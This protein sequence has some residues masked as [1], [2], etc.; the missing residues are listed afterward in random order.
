VNQLC[1]I[2]GVSRA[3]YYRFRRRHEPRQASMTLRNHIQQ[4]ALRWPAYGY[5]RVHAELVRQGWR[6]NHKRV[7]RLMRSDNLLCVR[8][9]K[10]LF[11]TDSRHSLPIYPN[12]VEELIVTSIDQLWV[13][14][15]TYIRL[16]L[17]FVYLAVLLDACSRR[18]LGW[19][20][21][22]SLEA[23]LALEALRMALRQRRPKP[24]LIHHSDRGVQY[25]SRDYTA[26]L[27]Q[28]GI[29]ISMSRTASPYDNAQAESFMK[30]LKYEEVYR[31]EYR[32]LEEA[33]A[34]I[35]EFLNKIYNRERLHSALGYRPPLEF[36]RHLRHTQAMGRG[37]A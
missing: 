26:E 15:I 2:A 34:S 18:C 21:R 36:E 17:E 35:G 28:H 27:Q 20:L 7:L 10:F 31:T 24:G 25:A 14:D 19:A 5:R 33:R 8:R 23:A 30:T 29:R 37:Q 11:T 6:I 9:R 13:A 22:R 12:L 4:I 1:Q 16:Q 3:G 32:C